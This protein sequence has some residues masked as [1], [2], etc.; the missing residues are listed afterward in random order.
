MTEALTSNLRMELDKTNQVFSRWADKKIDWLESNDADL[1][2]TMEECEYTLAALKENEKEMETLRT[3]NDEVKRNQTEEIDYYIKQKDV[4]LEAEKELLPKLR[5]LEEE[6][7]KENQRLDGVRKEYDQIRSQA[8]RSIDDLTHGIR[9]YSALGLEFQKAEGQSMKFIF[10]LLDPASPN[11]E[12][13]FLMFVDDSDK[14]K[15]VDSQPELPE[16]LATQLLT[17]LNNDNDIGKFVV[18]MRRSFQLTL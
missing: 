1:V 18:N 6:E 4:L 10:T 7:E 11:K 13:Y 17:A 16:S 8:E 9:M 12:F 3:V 5:I 15:L 14:Y 2:R